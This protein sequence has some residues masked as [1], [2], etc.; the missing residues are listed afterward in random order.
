MVPSQRQLMEPVA[1]GVL[2]Y[3]HSSTN[4]A[5]TRFAEMHREGVGAFPWRCR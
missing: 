5:D 3:A 2:D 1:R 4:L